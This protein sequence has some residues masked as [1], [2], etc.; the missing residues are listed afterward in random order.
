MKNGWFH[1]NAA[2]ERFDFHAAGSR[3][4]VGRFIAA[5][6]GGWY[7]APLRPAALPLITAAEST[8]LRLRFAT[9]DDDDQAA[10]YLSFWTGDAPAAA[11]RP[12][13]IV[14]YYLP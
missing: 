12:Q 11:D 3:G 8:Q 14:T 13:L 4:N 10:D 2:L 1:G 7:R 5:P 9:G 6:N